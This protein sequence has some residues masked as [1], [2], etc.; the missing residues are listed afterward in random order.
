MSA[1]ELLPVLLVRWFELRLHESV[2]FCVRGCRLYGLEVID[3]DGLAAGDPMAARVCFLAEDDDRESLLRQP[4]AREVLAF[5]AAALVTVEWRFLGGGRW[6]RPG[7]FVP[8]RRA[9]V[10]DLLV[11]EVG[12]TAIRFENDPEYVVLTPAS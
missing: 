6:A 5:D 12:V 8:R 9:R 4:D 2:G 11:G 10:V 7:E 1:A 3:P